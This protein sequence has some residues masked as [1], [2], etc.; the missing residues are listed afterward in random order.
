M[1]LYQ[2]AIDASSIE[3]TP[4][5][6][7]LEQVLQL[8]GT[9][10][11]CLMDWKINSHAKPMLAP[12][13]NEYTAF[14][15]HD[16]NWKGLEIQLKFE[17]ER[18]A[19][20]LT[21]SRALDR[22][23]NRLVEHLCNLLLGTFGGIY[24]SFSHRC[25]VVDGSLG[26]ENLRTLA[27]C[28]SAVRSWCMVLINAIRLNCPELYSD[29]YFT[30]NQVIPL[31]NPNPNSPAEDQ[32]QPETAPAP[33]ADF[34]PVEG[35]QPEL[36]K[37]RKILIHFY[38][39]GNMVERK[40]SDYN[41][42]ILFCSPTHRLAYPD[43]TNKLKPLIKDIETILENLT[44]KARQQADNELDILKLRLVVEK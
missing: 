17:L 2:S 24:D 18:R 1:D 11:L 36:S 10:F 14:F 30:F 12:I 22:F 42:Y 6:P 44:P 4:T 27:V 7:A 35:E 9:A 41:D 40:H 33:P 25:K 28:N 16:G 13:L 21:D 43:S 20:L 37:R 26:D 29:Y 39:G 23:G 8:S 3:I 32:Q 5:S 38:E 31:S 34:V 19:D 15:Q